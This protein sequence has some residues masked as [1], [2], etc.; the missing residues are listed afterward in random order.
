MER[1]L[2]KIEKFYESDT[3]GIRT[4]KTE[5][6]TIKEFNIFQSICRWPWMDLKSS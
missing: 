5:R 3:V 4:D 1:N 2:E 6:W